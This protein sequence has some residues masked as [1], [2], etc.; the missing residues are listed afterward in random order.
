MEVSPPSEKDVIVR[1]PTPITAEQRID[2]LKH[3]NRRRP[4]SG[5]LGFLWEWTKI[6]WISVALFLVLRTFI[7]EAFKIPS[8]SMERTLLIGDFLLVNKLAYGAE[9]PFT[10]KRLPALREP[11]RED[12]IVFEAPEDAS[13]TYVKRL[14]GLPGDTLEMRDGALYRNGARIPERYVTH[15]SDVDR[16]EERFRW[17]RDYIVPRA[18][19]S[20]TYHPTRNN[21]GPLVVPR[22]SYFVL[23]DNRDN[24]SDSRY[25]GFVPDSLVKGRPFVI[26]YSYAPDS[27]ESFAWL[28]RI[29]W[30]RLGE[31]VR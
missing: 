27:A 11:Q 19:A 16:V 4:W 30:N 31:L 26:Y 21:W 6:F 20:V 15:H 17:Q 2:A 10:H 3:V 7:V 28:T 8:G 23:G 13:K 24:S 12:V 25:W 22:K 5:G 1:R 9:I 29:R 18:N 14:V